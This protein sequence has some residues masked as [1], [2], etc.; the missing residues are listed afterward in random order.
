MRGRPVVEQQRR[1]LWTREMHQI[2]T[3]SRCRGRDAD[4][5]R[6]AAS[7]GQHVLRNGTAG[8]ELA[9][10]FREADAGPVDCS[11]A[12]DAADCNDGTRAARR[13]TDFLTR[14]LGPVAC[15]SAGGD[16]RGLRHVV[17]ELIEALRVIDRELAVVLLV[18]PFTSPLLLSGARR[19]EVRERTCLLE[20][21]VIHL[22]GAVLLLIRDETLE[23][24]APEDFVRE[25]RGSRLSRHSCGR[26][27]GEDELII[28]LIDSL[29]IETRYFGEWNESRHHRETLITRSKQMGIC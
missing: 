12:V 14:R 1:R 6:G 24:V 8:L 9:V 13:A 27:T 17:V 23:P 22:I 7:G 4:E 20:A 10:A 19:R 25:V 11:G 16:R 18:F 21:R 29:L 15:H 2:R 28:T 5:R 3:R 26:E